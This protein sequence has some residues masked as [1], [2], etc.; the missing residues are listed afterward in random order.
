MAC[1]EQIDTGI[2]PRCFTAARQE[3]W[4]EQEAGRCDYVAPLCCAGCPFGL[5]E[6]IQ[7]MKRGES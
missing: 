7:P 6:E 2:D 4:S 5:G 1:N 3:G